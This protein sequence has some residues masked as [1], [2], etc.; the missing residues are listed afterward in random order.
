M[1]FEKQTFV[2]MF[3]ELRLAD[4]LKSANRVMISMRL[5]VPR[6]FGVVAAMD[7]FCT[8][9]R[10]FGEP[11][12]A[13]VVVLLH[14]MHGTVVSDDRDKLHVTTREREFECLMV[15]MAFHERVYQHAIGGFKV[16]CHDSAIMRKDK[17][18]A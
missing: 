14:F 4:F 12:G 15:I 11:P 9:W 16:A 1:L 2:A 13:G 17:G 6:T 8:L 10:M 7:Q 3:D 5:I 18:E